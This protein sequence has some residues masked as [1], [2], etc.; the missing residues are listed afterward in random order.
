MSKTDETQLHDVQEDETLTVEENRGESGEPAP[1]DDAALPKYTLLRVWREVLSN[2]ETAKNEYIGMDVAGRI[3]NQWPHL[4]FQEVVRYHELFHDGL[5]EI[6]KVLDD[7]IAEHPSAIDVKG[8]EDLAENH[9]VYKDLIFR[10]NILLD[11][12]QNTWD[13]SDP[14]SHIQYAAFVDVRGFLFRDDGFAGHLEQLGF[15][16]STEELT[17]AVLAARDEENNE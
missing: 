2:V 16:L 6:R 7:V 9:A 11:R 3:I 5:L 14:E 10:W 1:W 8:E 12:K 4:T 13:V 17:E 15:T